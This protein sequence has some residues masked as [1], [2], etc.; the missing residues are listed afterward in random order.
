[1]A[2]MFTINE[3]AELKPADTHDDSRYKMIR[4]NHPIFPVMLQLLG[5]I[6][7]SR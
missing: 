3:L 2:K 6:F 4:G 7:R 5:F 1:M